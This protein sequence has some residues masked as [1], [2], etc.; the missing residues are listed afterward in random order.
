MSKKKDRENYLQQVALETASKCGLKV[1]IWDL[2]YYFAIN[3]VNCFNPDAMKISSYHKQKGD[4]VFLIS[5]E[6]EINNKYDII[7]I[8]KERANTPN[9]PLKFFLDDKVRWLGRACNF[10]KWNIPTIIL[11]MRPDYLLYPEHN[12][13]WERADQCRLF[14]N[15]G[16]LLTAVQDNINAFKNKNFLIV[17]PSYVI[18]NLTSS[19][20]LQK[21]LES[22]T[23]IKNLSFFEPININR[24]IDDK[25]VR[26]SFLKL[27]FIRNAKIA[28]LTMPLNNKVFTAIDIVKQLKENNPTAAPGVLDISYEE[29]FDSWYKDKQKA[30]DSFNFIK[31]VIIYAKRNK[32]NIKLH[33]PNYKRINILYFQLIETIINWTQEKSKRKSNF[34]NSSWL[35]YI[36]EINNIKNIDNYWTHPEHW[37]VSFRD[38]LRQTRQDKEFLLLQWGDKSLSLSEI[39]TYLWEK[40][41]AIGL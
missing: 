14:D 36:T 17:D 28:W 4:Q 22:L 12:T 33:I 16:Q 25:L 18:W 13:R 32:V 11:Q 24:L 38:L 6:Y 23:S 34:V 35:E 21:A 8:L 3:K 1:A 30:I 39:P 31:Q 41:F 7:Y 5:N 27:K 26:D 29:N 2:E 10:N 20:D 9:P 15:Q 40:E 37:S 19:S